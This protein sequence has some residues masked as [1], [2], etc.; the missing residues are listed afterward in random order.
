MELSGNY[1]VT[2]NGIVNFQ[3]TNKSCGKSFGAV[4]TKN[5][6][7]PS[8]QT[9]G[10][11][12]VNYSAP[13]S[14]TKIADVD[15]P[16]MKEKASV[17]KLANGQK[18]AVLPKKG[19]TFIKTS[20]GVGSMNE[21]D[22]LRGISHY[23]EHNLFNGSKG[24]AS[25]EYDKKV[26]AMGG[27]SNAATETF[28]TDYH[29]QLQLLDDKSLGEA[30]RLNALQT[31]FPT[32]PEEKLQKEKEIVKQEIDRYEKIG[33]NLSRN[34]MLKNLFGIESS[35]L[36]LVAGSKEKING[37]NRDIV[38]DYYN[39]WYTPDNT[40]TVIVGDVDVD[41]TMQLV[42]KNY[43]KKLDTSKV[44]NRK[45][46]ELKPINQPK[47]KDIFQTDN[48]NTA[49]SIGFPVEN[50][51]IAEQK[52][53][54]LM[55]DFL[56]SPTSQL[57]KRLYDL[58]VSANLSLENF[59]S[60]KNA[61]KLISATVEVPDE[62]SEEVLKIIYE[63][64][65]NLMNNP[66]SQDL[67]SRMVRN[68]IE[69][70]KNVSEYSECVGNQL[71]QMLKDENLNYFSE[72]QNALMQMNSQSVSSLARKYLDL[73]RISICVAHPNKT[74]ANDIIANYN[75]SNAV[76]NKATVSFGKSVSVANSIEENKKNV[77]Q[78]VLNN[79]INLST[80][81]TDNSADCSLQMVFDGDYNPNVSRAEAFV[82][83]ELLNRGSLFMGNDN[84]HSL[85]EQMN[86]GL[87]FGFSDDKICVS[88]VFD[89]NKTNDILPLMKNVLLNPNFTQQEFDKAKQ[90][91][92]QY[93][94]NSQKTPYHKLLPM[95]FPNNKKYLSFEEQI[96]IL[97]K[98]TLQDAQRIYFNLLNN[99]Q[100][101]VSVTLPQDSADF[102][103][104]S[105]I[106][107]LSAG[108]PVAR[109]FVKEKDM[110]VSLYQPNTQE[111]IICDSQETPQA[112][113][114][115]S[116]QYKVTNNLEDKVKIDLLSQILGGGMSSRL[117]EDL[118]EGEKITYHVASHAYNVSDVG[119]M[120]LE[121]GVSTD[122][123]LT[124]EADPN[125]YHKAI[126]GFNR[127]VQKIKNEYVS[128]DELNVA[129]TILKTNLLNSFESNGGKSL[130]AIDDMNSY[131][132]SDYTSK[133]LEIMEKIT[134]EDIKAAANY[135]F[136]NKPITSVVASQYTLDTLGLKK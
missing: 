72:K 40:V 90:N 118:R 45:Y 27:Y 47:R 122:P 94:E 103:E 7:L 38:L 108:M 16:G 87:S 104:Q 136:A 29:M 50:T 96:K 125:N 37:L 24:L 35:S 20:F 98:M 8:T 64:I 12:Q 78:Y 92:K 10:M 133:Y 6:E 13:V 105:V 57:T 58:G 129:K 69:N 14:Y 113:I 89:S 42:S 62:K 127:N 101:G 86:V 71:V 41:E 85:I 51:T 49:I 116:Y 121:I 123:N 124:T 73:N 53:I 21:P 79:N 30:I 22:N 106:N 75:N 60:D 100:C 130:N 99:S 84:Y 36:E 55:L 111:K 128:Q 34:E 28:Y 134:V 131:Y 65:S 56:N 66:P 1:K 33:S 2:N 3:K 59:S 5:V 80:V 135:V 43:N 91:V 61:P 19:P 120:E 126:N 95:I 132:G 74:N 11:S 82:I 114:L 25:G 17:F 15:I 63:E 119:F 46:E 70:M 48:P 52:Q 102:V 88:G 97:D 112:E 81:K 77:K 110:Q 39:T 109:P 83:S 26:K 68:E 115:Q 44:N 76:N 9:V 54:S 23:I 4:E 31:Q 93:F 18:V 32:F 107:Q 67:V 117:F